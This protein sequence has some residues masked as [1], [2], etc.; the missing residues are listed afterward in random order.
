ML[1]PVLLSLFNI[2]DLIPWLPILRAKAYGV[3]DLKRTVDAIVAWHHVCAL[4]LSSQRVF[5]LLRM[6]ARPL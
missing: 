6:S 1:L 2:L 5:S 3:L 4:S